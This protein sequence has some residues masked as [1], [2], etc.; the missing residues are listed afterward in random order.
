MISWRSFIAQDLKVS[1]AWQSQRLRMA[2]KPG[3]RRLPAEMFPYIS[4]WTKSPAI[5]IAPNGTLD[6]AFYA[7][8][9]DSTTCLLDV[10]S[11]RSGL[12]SGRVDSCEYNVFYT[13]SKDGGLTFASPLKVNQ[14]P[15]RGEDFVRYTGDSELGSP[16]AVSSSNDFAYPIWIGTPQVSKTQ[17]FTAKIAR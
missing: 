11:W 9:S 2:V 5:S 10:E 6:L 14:E 8:T 13:Y 1:R 7:H 16:L 15:I 12:P 17:V 3:A 4:M